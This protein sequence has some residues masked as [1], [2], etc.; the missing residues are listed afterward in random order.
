MLQK[1][2]TIIYHVNDLQKAKEFYISLTGIEPYF[3]E[4]FYVGFE[5]AGS[6][7]GLDPDMTTVKDGNH[8]VAY[9][10]VEDIEAAVKKALDLNAK[11]IT[12]TT[13]VGII[14]DL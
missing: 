11:L 6:E 14:L 5:I 8:S 9:W 1:L 3:D 7:L 2:R 10:A 13:N 4:P 12:P